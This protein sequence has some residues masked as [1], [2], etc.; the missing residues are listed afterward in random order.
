MESYDLFTVGYIG[1]QL[2]RTPPYE[3]ISHKRGASNLGTENLFPVIIQH[4]T[5]KYLKKI[6]IKAVTVSDYT[7]RHVPYYLI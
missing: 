1:Y 6:K 5:V 3:V 7:Y 4:D 2:S